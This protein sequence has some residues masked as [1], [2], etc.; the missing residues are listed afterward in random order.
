MTKNLVSLF[1]VCLILTSVASVQH[2]DAA[3]GVIIVPDDYPSIT[4]AIANA[5]DGDV[6]YVKSGVYNE[7][8]LEID[9]SI[10]I[11]GQDV[12]NTIINLN[13]P[14]TSFKCPM[15]HTHFMSSD[16]VEIN[17]DNVKIAALTISTTGGISGTGDGI[18][19][20]SNIITAGMSAHLTGSKITI[21]RNRLTASEWRLSGSNLTLAENK[22]NPIGREILCE[23]NYCNIYGNAIA[24]TLWLT[25]S[26]NTIT[27]NSYEALFLRQGDSNL[28][29]RNFG[30][31]SLGNPDSPCTNNIISGNVLKGSIVWGIWIGSGCKN[32]LFYDNYI[33]DQCNDSLSNEYDSG[34]IFCDYKGIASGNTFYNNVFVNNTHQ[35]RFYSDVISG[36]NNWG[37]A[38]IGNYWDDYNGTDA[39]GDG[40][41]D[42]P[43]II[44]LANS[45]DYPLITQPFDVPTIIVPPPV[46]DP[47]K[48]LSDALLPQPD[49]AIATPNPTQSAVSKNDSPAKQS[50][51]NNSPSL[52]EMLPE[53]NIVIILLLMLTMVAALFLYRARSS[54]PK[55]G[56]HE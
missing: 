45:D 42:T 52:L 24:G 17:A 5:A 16:A 55:G 50:S 37:N 26:S 43:Y 36:G 35:V 25:G 56:L 53:I 13:P 9:R 49:I 18:E 48:K 1:L 41:G 10:T 22:I 11:R 33:A 31:L 12:R 47:P 6:I 46:Y 28:I 38:T 7:T 4:Q 21:A 23:G 40:I 8:V 27:V 44:N 20:V 34:V 3:S 19:V 14:Q 29:N 32:N 54:I 51:A 2:V 39:N 15:G 30:E